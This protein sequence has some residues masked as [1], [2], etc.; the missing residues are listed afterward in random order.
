M[1][2]NNINTE[3]NSFQTRGCCCKPNS[4]GNNKGV[5]NKMYCKLSDHDWLEHISLPTGMKRF[6]CVEVRFKNS[7]KDFYRL[8]GD[9]EIHVG[10]I[11]AV[12]ASPGHDIGIVSLIGE[13]A[14]IQMKRKEI[15]ENSEK[16]KKLY[17]R[18]RPSDIEKWIASVDKE[19]KTM[20]RTKQITRDLDLEM[21]MNDVEYQ[22][23]G[24]KAVFYYTA[25]DR[26]DFRQL[27]KILAEE[28]KIR[29]EMR[30]IGVRQEAARLGGIGSC[31]RELCCATWMC[32]FNSVTT[33]SAR[34]QQLSLNPQKLAGQCSKLK[35]CLNF[36]Q[37]AYIDA[38][39]N[40]PDNTVVLKTK[41]GEA[42]HQKTDVF[43]KTMWY[44]YTDEPANIVG[45][46]IRKVKQI[47][48]MN[49]KGKRPEKL[50]NFVNNEDPKND[51]ENVVW[52][53]DLNRFDKKKRKRQ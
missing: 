15:T 21:K 7:R 29:I 36:E 20:Y 14:R 4:N 18:A 42:I 33:N 9:F 30:Q 32:S 1:S 27:I 44:S 17:R 38:L 23:D 11:V 16:I 43:K 3:H 35:C 52:Q 26:V 45:L 39:K 10:D 28:F 22:G 49:R 24:T 37:D 53:D 12:E 46:S 41:K 19:D 40:F 13:S 25:E 50:E 8:Q 2:D 31:G 47:V 34:T 51:F 48:D 5:Y 6:D